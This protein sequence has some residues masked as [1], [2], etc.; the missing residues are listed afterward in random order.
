MAATSLADLFSFEKHFEDAAETFLESAIGISVFPQASAQDFVTPRI[1]IQFVA[2]EAVY[3]DDSP[4][5]SVPALAQAEFRKYSGTF[6]ARIITDGT[7]GQTRADHFSYVGQT[8]AALLRSATNW[9]A[10]S[11]PYY[12]LKQIRQ[13]STF[14]ETDGDLQIS[15]VSYDISFSIRSDAFPE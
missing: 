7:Q 13:S 2:G 6:E 5:T 10:T 11:L 3:P 14:R 4:I 8:R 15:T 9:D 1:E 12:G